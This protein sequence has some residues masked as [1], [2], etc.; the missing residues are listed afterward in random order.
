[1]FKYSSPEKELNLLTLNDG[2]SPLHIAVSG[3]QIELALN[4]L[5]HGANVN[6]KNKNGDT[7]L[8]LAMAFPGDLLARTL[9][10]YKA[11]LTIKNNSGKKPS[12][13]ARDRGNQQLC[14]MMIE[15]ENNPNA[16]PDPKDIQKELSL[17]EAE[18]IRKFTYKPIIGNG[19]V[20]IS[21]INELE[22]R[23]QV[24]EENIEKIFDILS[25]LKPTP[26]QA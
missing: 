22:E 26:T 25:K 8:H 24:M 10:S 16:F 21:K 14:D 13:I 9:L 18:K 6:A 4:L 7:P 19:S 11:D 3:G 5:A 2:S 20:S 12:Q 17:L 15:Y 1:M 23:V